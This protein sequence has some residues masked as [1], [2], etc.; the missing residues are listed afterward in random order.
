[1][2]AT[3]RT[4]SPKITKDPCL[5]LADLH[6]CSQPLRAYTILDR[7]RGDGLRNSLH[8]QRALEK[9]MEAGRVH[10]LESMNAFVV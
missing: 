7:F 8:V 9:L 3:A 10:C 2:K 4:D 5:V 1:M 6:S